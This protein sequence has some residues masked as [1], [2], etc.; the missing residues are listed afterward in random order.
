[1]PA[2]PLDTGSLFARIAAVH[3]RGR[4]AVV[5]RDGVVTYGQ[6]LDHAR[7]LAARLGPHDAPLLIYGDRQPAMVVGLVAALALGR[8]Y[9]PLDAASPS[10]RISRILAASR[11][12]TRC[13]RNSHRRGSRAS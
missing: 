5:G 12:P 11:R 4:P 10:D 2:S 1:M 13:W 6:L 3:D 8:P 9:V 7:R